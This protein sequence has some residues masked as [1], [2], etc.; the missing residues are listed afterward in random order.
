M[1]SIRQ[2]IASSP[3]LNEDDRRVA[4][5]KKLFKCGHAHVLHPVMDDPP[6]E[7]ASS[8]DAFELVPPVPPHLAT[9]WLHSALVELARSR[10]KAQTP[11]DLGLE[12]AMRAMNLAAQEKAEAVS[13]AAAHDDDGGTT[14]GEAA[15]SPAAEPMAPNDREDDGFTVV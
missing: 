10:L 8:S 5:A 4:A 14:G 6:L 12:Q 13:T 15:S 7:F 11:A 9:P 1:Q 3:D 2:L